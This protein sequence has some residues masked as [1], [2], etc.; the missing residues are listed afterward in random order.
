MRLIVDAQN[1]RHGWSLGPASP[2]SDSG[3]ASFWRALRRKSN[4]LHF[5]WSAY[6]KGQRSSQL[7]ANGFGLREQIQ[8]V[9][10]TGLGISS[11]HVE[12]AKGMYAHH[13]AG[14][15]AVQVQIADMEFAHGAVELLAARAVGGTG[16]AELGAIGDGER[17]GK[18]A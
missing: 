14:G 13:R 6:G 8:I 16:E 3:P 5:F 2:G 18:I 12:A 7:F 15:F 17:V 4:R 1:L 9:G 11:T 10:S